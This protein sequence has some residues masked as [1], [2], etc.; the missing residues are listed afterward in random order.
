MDFR[1][2]VAGIKGAGR[3][4]R[5]C[6]V[7]TCMAI[8]LWQSMDQPGKVTSPAR[9]QLNRKP[10]PR[11]R[12]RN[13]SHETG[14][15]SPISLLRLNPVLNRGVPFNLRGGV[16]LFIIYLYR[17]PPSSGQ[18]RACKVKK[19]R[20]VGV[21]CRESAGTRPVVLTS[22]SSD[23]CCLCRCHNGPL[24]LCLSF[25]ASTV[26]IIRCSVHA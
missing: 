12:L 20:T 25:P 16:H 22:S 15:A 24:F 3:D 2:S 5:V 11:S 9:G 26:I 18:S 13:W 14:L 19:S 8:H 6:M 7:I 1:Q 23:G 21:Y 4:A 17:H 10:C